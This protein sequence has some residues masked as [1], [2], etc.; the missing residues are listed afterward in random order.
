M[1]ESSADR[2]ECKWEA[3]NKVIVHIQ[4]YKQNG[5]NESAVGKFHYDFD[6]FLNLIL[7]SNDK[8][9]MTES[10]VPAESAKF[11]DQA[12]SKYFESHLLNRLKLL[13][14]NTEINT[15]SLCW[16]FGT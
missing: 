2:V 15:R 4:S 3:G 8:L 10:T 5:I 6:R 11:V 16:E 14:D 1:Y 12:A 9:S 7:K 13:E